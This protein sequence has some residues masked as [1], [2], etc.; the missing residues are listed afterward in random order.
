MLSDFENNAS[1]LVLKH[2]DHYSHSVYVFLIGL[3]IYHNNENYRKEY[4]KAY[5]DA[6]ECDEKKALHIPLRF[7]LNRLSPIL[8]SVPMRM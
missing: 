8:K 6:E 1:N 4:G 7:L 2:R 3:A 5:F